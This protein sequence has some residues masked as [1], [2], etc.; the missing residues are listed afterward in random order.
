MGKNVYSLVLMDDVVA[1]IDQMAYSMNTSRSNLINQILAEAVSYTTPEKRIRSIFDEVTRLFNQENSFQ[2]Q[3]QPS[4]AMLSIRSALRFKYNP[5]IRYAVELYRSRG[6]AFGELRVM[7]RTQSRQLLALLNNF[8]Q[9]LIYLEQAYAK[10]YF[11]GKQVEYRLEEGRL[12]RTFVLKG[13]EDG[14]AEPTDEE[15]GGAIADYIKMVDDAVKT[16]FEH[17][18]RP[19]EALQRLE[20]VYQS[21]LTTTHLYI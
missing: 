9:D 4:D 11:P 18:D 12:A 17:S 8:F 19:Q 3:L 5:T 1:K 15:L 2:I 21:Y 16:Y 10:K 7:T 14:R 13:G 20:S 6:Q